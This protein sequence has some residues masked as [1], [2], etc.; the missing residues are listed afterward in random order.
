MFARSIRIASI[1]FALLAFI[2]AGCHT[3]PL[4]DPEK[5]AVD[6]KLNGWYQADKPG[7]LVFITPYDSRTS[8]ATLYGYDLDGTAIK[9]QTKLTNKAWMTAV[10][11]MDVMTFKIID[12]EW[13]LLE[14]PESAAAR[15]SYYRIRKLE[16]GAVEATQ[17]NTD[18]LRDTKTPEEL[19]K[20]IADNVKNDEL[21]KNSEPMILRPVAADKLEDVKAIVKAFAPAK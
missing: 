11:G 18:F 19:A 13:D 21:W 10:G 9:P 4:G 3:V 1:S 17:L 6:A 5:S 20:K 14:S 15:Y 7:T 2:A 12:P 8:I 16:G